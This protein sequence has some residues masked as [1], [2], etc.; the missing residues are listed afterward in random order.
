MVIKVQYFV[1]VTV[2]L[3]VLLYKPQLLISHVLMYHERTILLKS[4]FNPKYVCILG[5][6]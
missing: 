4:I 6:F 2:L 3:V 5:T 1:G